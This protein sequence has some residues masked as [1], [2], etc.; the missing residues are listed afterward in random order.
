MGLYF[1]L[2]AHNIRQEEVCRFLRHLLAH[3]RGA[4]IVV[5]DNAGIHRGD[6]IRQLLRR[7]PRLRLEPLSAYAPERN[8]DE[9][10]WNHAKRELANGR[11]D[12]GAGLAAEVLSSLASL[13]RSP[14][15]LRG[16]IKQSELPPFL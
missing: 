13:K 12:D 3:L 2:Y 1:C 16:C 7:H 10:V 6:A 4:I 15:R 11:P 14:S 9:G 8:P 5:W